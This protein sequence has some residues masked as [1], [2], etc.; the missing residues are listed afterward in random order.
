VCV[1]VCVACVLSNLRPS[2]QLLARMRV[3]DLLCVCVC[4]C[5]ASVD[6][7]VCCV[8]VCV[9]VCVACVL[10]TL[11]LSVQVLARMRVEV[12]DL[13]LTHIYRER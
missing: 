13:G 2:L 5:D 3:E 11:R 8:C 9:C 1:C 6:F 12:P 10:L 4:V 7:V